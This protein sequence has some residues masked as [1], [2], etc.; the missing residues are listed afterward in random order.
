MPPPSSFP[1]SEI[2]FK[3]TFQEMLSMGMELDQREEV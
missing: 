1:L 3:V 2:G